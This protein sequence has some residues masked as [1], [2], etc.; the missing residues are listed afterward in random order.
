MKHLAKIAFALLALSF[1]FWLV[2]IDELLRVL[3]GVDLAWLLAV[4]VLP[5]LSIVVSSMKWRLFLEALGIR[6]TLYVLFKLY[7]VG[8]FFNN[9]LPSTVG[10][11]IARSY[12]LGR[13][14]QDNAGTIAAIAA[15]RITGVAVLLTLLPAVFFSSLILDSYPLVALAA[16]LTW[17]MF[18][19][20][21]V[22][23]LRYYD[24]RFLERWQ[25]IRDHKVTQ[26]VRTTLQKL[27]QFSRHRNT[28]VAALLLSLVFYLLAMLTVYCA[29]RA[30]GVEISMEGILLG[31]PLVLFVGILPISFNGLGISEIGWIV[32][33]N[34]YGVPTA[35]CAAIAVLL[36]GRAVATALWGASILH[37]WRGIGKPEAET[38]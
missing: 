36:R 37:Y 34:L 20:A 3:A 2:D 16:P 33:L 4:L 7:L 11:D 31:V 29:G 30:V 21:V 6:T 27:M 15:E 38:R 17:L 8:T 24:L 23:L 10:G 25:V 35:E 12:L 22:L 28:V 9:F 32:V 26:L 18:I 5:H 14:A 13:D 19:L 1:A